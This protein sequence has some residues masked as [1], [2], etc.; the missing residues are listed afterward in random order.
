M[1]RLVK[2]FKAWRSQFGPYSP[3]RWATIKAKGKGRFVLRQTF[4]ITVY[5]VAL[6]DLV[7]Q[8]FDYGLPFKFGLYIFQ[9]LFMGVWIGY[10]TWWDHEAKYKKALKSSPQTFVQLH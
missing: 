6:Y 4:C 10:S 1:S 2:A 8:L 3:E 7:T 5:G 9:F